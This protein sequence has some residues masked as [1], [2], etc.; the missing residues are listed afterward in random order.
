MTRHPPS[1]SLPLWLPR[2]SISWLTRDNIFAFG[3]IRSIAGLKT[4]QKYV[5]K[6]GMPILS[7]VA[8][9]WSIKSGNRPEE[10]NTIHVV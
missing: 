7:T 2:A 9:S 8:L 5:V 4:G 3:F 1:Y 6:L 10:E